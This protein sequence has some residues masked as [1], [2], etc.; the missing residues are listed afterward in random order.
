MVK[1][2]AKTRHSHYRGP[3]YQAIRGPLLQRARM[4]TD[5]KTTAYA[6]HAL[7]V[8]SWALVSDGWHDEQCRP[9]INYV[10]VSPKGA[11]FVKA[12]DASGH[13]KDAEFLADN[14]GEVI[15]E[16]GADNVHLVIQDGATA[17]VACNRLL[18]AR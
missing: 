15:E 1:A 18:E 13:K 10:L 8:T 16:V 3:S 6:E 2:L 17:N 9:L 7:R 12:V 11:K 14:L 5:S 4:R